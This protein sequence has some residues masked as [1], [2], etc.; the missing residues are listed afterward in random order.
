MVSAAETESR[1]DRAA[2]SAGA[3]LRFAALLCIVMCGAALRCAVLYGAVYC[4]V[5][6]GKQS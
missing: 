6:T 5:R 2:D 1:G 4:A 3:V